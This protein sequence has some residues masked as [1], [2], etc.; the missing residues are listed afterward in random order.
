MLLDADRPHARP[1][2]TVRNAECLVQ[3]DVRDVAADVGQRRKPDE[4][5]EIRAV[6]VHL[7][8]GCVDDRA[9]FADLGLE[10]AVRGRVRQHDRA[11]RVCVLRGLRP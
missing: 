10:D 9:D 3:I 7:A 4:R 2:A 6:D 5:V 11:E 8:A 1:A